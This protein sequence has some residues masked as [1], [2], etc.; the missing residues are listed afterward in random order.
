[1][2]AKANLKRIAALLAITCAAILIHG[3]HPYIED[4][5]IYAPGIKQILHPDLY[6]Y[7]Q[8]FF[9]SHA[10][11]TL[12]PNLIAVS[13]RITHL[14]LDWVLFVWHFGTVF[15]LLLA[16]WRVA[17]LLFRDPLA[18]WSA[19][20]LIAAL[21]TLP[22]AGTA[23]YIMDQY[24]NPRSI[25]TPAILFGFAN[26]GEKK[27]LRATTWILFTGLIHPL[28]VLFAGAFLACYFVLNRRFALKSDLALLGL[29]LT[30]IPK[31]S[32]AY[33][34]VLDSH[35]YFLLTRWEWYEWL[36]ALAPLLILW[37]LGQ[38]AKQQR[39]RTLA[40]VCRSLIVFQIV[41]LIMGLVV[42][43]PSLA[44]FSRI[45]PMR[46]LHLLYVFLFIMCGGLFAQPVLKTHVWRWLALLIP[47]CLGMWFAQQQLFPATEHLELPGRASRNQWVEAFVWI[48][49]HTPTDAYFALNPDH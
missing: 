8:A 20:A 22:V 32:K 4:A 23:L 47:I 28:M 41:F 37:W 43:A 19:V 15:A 49:E 24:V 42:C 29:P 33:R 16:C 39:L 44:A 40:V 5:E 38:V 14:P 7:N 17:A 48:R 1:M 9:A 6:P 2:P 21:L 27:F 35:S 10:H 25:S 46:G 11:L 45:Q 12:F 3:Y 36:G 30:F 31:V 13:A 18:P 34:E 26:F